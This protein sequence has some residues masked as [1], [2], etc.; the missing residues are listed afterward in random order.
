M[1]T[2]VLILTFLLAA[3]VATAQ[4]PQPPAEEAA[5]DFSR[6]TLLRIFSENPVREDVDPRF[7]ATLGAIEFRTRGINWRIGYLPFFMPLQG[8]MP[9]LNSHRW[10]DPFTLTG[11]HIPHTSRTWRDERALNAEVRK[12]E[13]RIRA[14]QAEIEVKR[15]P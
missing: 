7:R 3:T 10:P 13:R 14:S 11:T 8:S 9:W 1:R 15:D 6:D 5:P 12:I 4:E 2:T